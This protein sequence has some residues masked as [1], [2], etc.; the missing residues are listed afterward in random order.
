MSNNVRILHVVG[1]MNRGGVE[2]WLMH[3]L[4]SV[5]RTR[6]HMDFCV[7]SKNSAA[8]DEEIR[9]MGSQVFISPNYRNPVLYATQLRDILRQHGPYDVI[10]SH[11]HHYSGVV[12]RA[13]H[14]LNVPV[15]IA[16]SHIDT[17]T[18]DTNARGIRRLYLG[19]MRKWIARYATAGL[20]VSE[21]AGKALWRAEWGTD[22]RWLLLYYGIDLTQFS[23]AQRASEVRGELGIPVSAFVVGHVGRFDPQKNHA[24]LIR[25][26]A[27]LA[28]R[29]QNAWLLLIG[30]GPLRDRVKQ[31][32]RRFGTESRV[33]YAGVRPDVPRLLLGAIDIFLFPSL[34]EGLPVAVLEAQAAGVPTVLSD[35]ITREVEVIP[36]LLTWR[37]LS[38]PVA[39]WT[40]ACATIEKGDSTRLHEAWRFFVGTPFDIR[41]SVQDLESMYS[42][43]TVKARCGKQ[44]G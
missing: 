28:E 6:I 41:S 27:R 43:Q 16:H 22:P 25:V 35:A 9:A 24:F 26:F 8:F 34:F 4:R 42:H 39:L 23:Q 20:A 3:V 44:M 32:T 33:V 31:D 36:N 38:E 13:A 18:S 7:H 40:D 5:D 21:G 29:N 17:R 12:L 30:D 10:H 15:R 37:S 19:L 14:G 11:V 1:A 2:T